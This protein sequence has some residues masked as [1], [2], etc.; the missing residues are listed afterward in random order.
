MEFTELKKHLA[1]KKYYPCYVL[2][3]EDAFVVGRAAEMLSRI[4][5]L[6]DF[7]LSLFGEEASGA[8]VALACR[9]LPVM[10]DYRVVSVAGLKRDTA[11]VAAYLK[12]PS[13]STVLVLRYGGTVDAGVQKF[14]SLYERVDCAKLPLSVVRKWIAQTVSEAGAQI[15]TSAAEALISRCGGDMTRISSETEKLIGAAD[16]TI[17]E[18]LVNELVTPDDDYKI[19][20]LG[21]ALASLDADRTYAVYGALVE[22]MPA[23]GLIANLYGYF[24]RLLYAA[25]TDDPALPGYLGV[26]EYAVKAAV[27]QGKKFGA[28]R[29][30]RIVDR[31][32]GI[33]RDFKAGLTGDREA[34]DTFIAET[35][36]RGRQ[37]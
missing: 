17:T 34:L 19:Y 24:R 2:A 6:P 3:G 14:S 8:D 27:R 21:D 11:A 31:L 33:D 5:E 12:E 37:N 13:P 7:N 20:E 32:N 4:A 15:T 29:L 16:G 28:V 23:A 36:T 18:T 1:L 35:L 22:A 10:S 25:I 9:Q 26:K 30:K